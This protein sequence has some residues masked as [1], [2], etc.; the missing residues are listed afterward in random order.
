MELLDI[1]EYGRFI[2]K[3]REEIG[4]S[5]V[6]LSA[7]SG[8]SLSTLTQIEQLARK[9]IRIKTLNKILKSLEN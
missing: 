3:R 5:Q 8:V 4:L 7:K 1:K 2:K 6:Q 9:D